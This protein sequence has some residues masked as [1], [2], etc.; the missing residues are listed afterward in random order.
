MVRS[1]KVSNYAVVMKDIV[2]FLVCLLLASV[3]LCTQPAQAANKIVNC[4]NIPAQIQEDYRQ[5]KVGS[6]RG[7]TYNNSSGQGSQIL[8]SLNRGEEYQEY[9]VGKDNPNLNNRG[10]YRIVALVRTEK[11]GKKIYD[12]VYLT[13]DHYQTFCKIK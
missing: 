11:N 1:S 13:K 5:I 6:V 9:D 3:F 7:R 8:P 10:K 2:R 12:P 4:K